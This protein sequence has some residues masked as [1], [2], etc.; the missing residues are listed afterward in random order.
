MQADF[1]DAH[2]RHWHDAEKLH[3]GARWA[4][5]DHLYGLAV[6]C[7]LKRLMHEFGMALGNG[8]SPAKPEDRK[9]A[10]KL[11]VRYDAYRA[12]YHNGVAYTLPAANP[13]G[14][15]SV[16]QRYANQREFDAT[17]VNAHR[18]GADTI[19]QLVSKARADGLIA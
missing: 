1:H 17:R 19:R 10:D 4:N 16:E 13:F 8:G 18:L 12:G 7:G 11:W 5:A 15:W 2:D 14:D 3:S 6:E 9:H